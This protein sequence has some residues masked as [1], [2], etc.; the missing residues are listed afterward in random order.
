M[1]PEFT[2]K[3][4]K[5]VEDN[6]FLEW[7]NSGFNKHHEKWSAIHN[8]PEEKEEVDLAIEMVQMLDFEVESIAP[9]KKSELFNRINDTIKEVPFEKK[10]KE[11]RLISRRQFGALGLAASFVLL[12]TVFWPSND[13]LNIQTQLGEFT[14]HTLPD[15]S[16]VSINA[17]SNL[18]YNSNN[19]KGNR[20]LQLDGE[21]FFDV[22]KGSSFK[23]NTAL[24]SVE[25]LGTSF[26]VFSRDSNFKV[27]CETGKVRVSSSS[28]DEVILEPGESCSLIDNKLVKAKRNFSSNSWTKGVFRFDDNP[29]KNVISE[30]ERQYAITV[31]A[32]GINTEEKYTGFFE[33]GNLDNALQSVFTTLGINYEKRSGNVILL[34]K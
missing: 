21:A 17:K 8:N 5:Y 31:E 23:V 12:L 25:V 27:V 2:D 34:S 26:N 29:L 28:S 10:N 13:L 15:N 20:Q 33:K 16:T 30:L 11:R 1:N 6:S 24:G 32:S 3:S 9:Q 18:T 19:F 14:E 4:L 22:E 7:V